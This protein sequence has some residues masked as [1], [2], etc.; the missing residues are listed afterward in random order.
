MK[1]KLAMADLGINSV[2]RVAR[3]EVANLRSLIFAFT[4]SLLINVIKTIA[5]SPRRNLLHLPYHC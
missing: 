4:A 5:S 1:K 3:L 2:F